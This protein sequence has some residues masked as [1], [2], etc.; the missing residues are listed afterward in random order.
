MKISPPIQAAPYDAIQVANEFIV[1][2]KRDE[3]QDMTNLKIQKLVYFAHGYCL[4]CEDHP[5]IVENFVAWKH[6]PVVRRLYDEIKQIRLQNDW[7]TK[8]SIKTPLLLDKNGSFPRMN[9]DDTELVMILDTV[10]KGFKNTRASALSRV[11]H[12]YN[13]PWTIVKY[14]DGLGARIPNEEI[15]RYFQRLGEIGIE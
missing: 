11:T 6:G 14:R 7:G 13:S 4:A 5:L 12:R 15:K 10:W 1:R 8:Q 2:G 3:I 9:Q